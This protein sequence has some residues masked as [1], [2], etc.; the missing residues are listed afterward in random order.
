M[1]TQATHRNTRL[2]AILSL[3]AASALLVEVALQPCSAHADDSK[4]LQRHAVASQ[5]SWTGFAVLAA[6]FSGL[7]AAPNT[8]PDENDHR[9]H[10]MWQP[11]PPVMRSSGI[12]Q[13]PEVT[14]VDENR[15]KVSLRSDLDTDSPVMLNFI[16][17]ACATLCPA[18]TATFSQVQAKLDAKAE[19]VK[20]VSISIDPEHDTPEKLKE[21]AQKYNVGPEW[22]MLTG[23]VEDSIAVQRAFNTYRSDKM[24]HAPVTFLRAG[25]DSPWVRLD[26]LASA[27]D[28]LKEYRRLMASK[29][30]P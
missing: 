14:L 9:H 27:G 8:S 16:F 22:Q 11:K 29:P 20:M 21:Y 18:M 7:I 25:K 26:G 15:N 6:L 17:T 2:H 13:V 12:Y 28:L 1:D 5:T 19:P 10:A 23:S 3:I 4:D 30:A 24:N